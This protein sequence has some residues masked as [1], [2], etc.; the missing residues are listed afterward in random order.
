MSKIMTEGF[1]ILVESITFVNTNLIRTLNTVP[2]I[3]L[4]DLI[5]QLIIHNIT[6]NNN[7]PKRLLWAGVDPNMPVLEVVA[8]PKRPPGF[9]ACP[10]K[11]VEP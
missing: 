5:T 11:L 6:K 4:V 9:G 3:T 10:N 2:F 1:K 7:L 8:V